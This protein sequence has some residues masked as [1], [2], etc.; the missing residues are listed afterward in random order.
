MNKL[1]CDNY[2]NE[3]IKF[4][5]YKKSYFDNKNLNNLIIVNC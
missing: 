3:N 1:I 2:W 4:Q 5:K